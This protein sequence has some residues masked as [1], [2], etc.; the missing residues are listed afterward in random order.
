MTARLWS[1]F[2]PHCCYYYC[3]FPV[4]SLWWWWWQQ[5]WWCWWQRWW[6]YSSSSHPSPCHCDTVVAL[7]AVHYSDRLKTKVTPI[8]NTATIWRLLAPSS[9]LHYLGFQSGRWQEK[10]PYWHWLVITSVILGLV[11]T[12]FHKQVAHWHI[13]GKS[14][15]HKRII[16]TY[17]LLA[18]TCILL[19]PTW[20]YWHSLSFF[21]SWWCLIAA[22]LTT[23]L[24]SLNLLRSYTYALSQGNITIDASPSSS[25]SSSP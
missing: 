12:I 21:S 16:G 18:P 4:R 6:W 10:Y 2:C 11:F 3:H 19:A 1:P 25:S 9:R 14:F 20:T 15:T 13:F 5:Q 7:V 17:R 24:S 8:Q 23:Q 22:N